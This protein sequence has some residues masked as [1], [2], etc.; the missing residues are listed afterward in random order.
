[1]S[2]LSPP[3]ISRA[4]AV[5]HGL[6]ALILAAMGLWG[7]LLYPHLPDQVP[8]HWNLRGEADAFSQKSVHGTFGLLLV[9]GGLLLF[10]LVVHLVLSRS[11]HLV[12]AE[13]RAYDLTFGY[14]NLSLALLVAWVSYSGW[15]G[16]SLGPLFMAFALLAGTPVLILFGLHLP[17][18]SKDRKAMADANEPS[19][20]PRYWVWNGFLYNNPNDPRAFVPKPPHTGTGVTVNLASPGG[21]LALMG[22]LLVV[23]GSL[24]LPFIL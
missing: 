9:A 12:P 24:A 6:A 15:Y 4:A 19:M 5:M 11:R 22:L 20:D 1:M 17:A 18:I 21:R 14:V 8:T 23:V 3:P 10:V 7:A 16:L 2:E 13:R